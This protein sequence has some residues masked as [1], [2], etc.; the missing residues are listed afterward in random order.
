M[1]GSSRLL[2]LPPDR[3]PEVSHVPASR[4]HHRVQ[5]RHRQGD[6]GRHWPRWARPPCWPA[7]PRKG[8][9][10]AAEVRFERVRPPTL[11]TSSPSIWPTCPRSNR[12][13]KSWCR[14]GTASTCWST[15]PAASGQVGRITA[16]GFEQTLGVNHLGPFLFTLLLLD[17]QEASS[18]PH[19]EPL[20]VRSPW[21]VQGMRWEDLNAERRY[22]TF[23]AYAQ[24]KLANVLFTLGPGLL[25]W[26]WHR[27][28]SQRRASRPRAE[29]VR[30]GR[31]PTRHVPDREL[32]WCVRSK[33][34]PSPMAW[35]HHHHPRKQ[36]PR[37]SSRPPVATTPWWKA[38][39][40]VQAGLD[41][42]PTPTG[43]GE[44]ASNRSPKP[45][46]AVALINRHGGSTP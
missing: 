18:R 30:D 46:S 7:A 44:S 41:P 42:V 12:G 17:R 11:S 5:Y 40:D 27:S 2:A 29:R 39:T 1:A 9:A 35:A 4:R 22:S 32:S 37:S 8:E 23:G 10:A 3:D 45:G 31:R 16:Q 26:R 13:A 15:T 25:A 21:R 20:L 36:R 19:R 6:G 38:R 33:R 34:P 28:H 14:A 43:S 24:S